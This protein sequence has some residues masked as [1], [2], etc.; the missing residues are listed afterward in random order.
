LYPAKGYFSAFLNKKILCADQRKEIKS[1][2]PESILSN[3]FPV[4]YS[5]NAPKIR[6]SPR[7]PSVKIGYFIQDQLCPP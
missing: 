4:A 1:E 7:L 2:I 6:E 3:P 5:E